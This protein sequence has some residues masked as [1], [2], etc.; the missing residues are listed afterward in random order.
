MLINKLLEE[1]YNSLI[2]LGLK[3]GENLEMGDL[4]LKATDFYHFC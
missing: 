4:T 2:S 1:I 3:H